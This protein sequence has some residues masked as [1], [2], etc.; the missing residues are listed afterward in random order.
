MAVQIGRSSLHMI[1]AHVHLEKGDYTIEWVQKFVQQAVERDIQEI[2]FLEHTHIFKECQ[3]LYNEMSTFN[4]YQRGWYQ[5]KLQQARPLKEYT[6]FIDQLKQTEFPIKMKFGLEVC[7]SPEREKEIAQLKE[8]YSFDFMV[9]SIHFIDGW[10]FSHLKQRWDKTEY[11][12]DRLYKRYY[13]LMLALAE[14]KLFS[15]LAHP[16]SLQCFGAY[17]ERDYEAVYMEIAQA[18]HRNQ[19]Y[20]EESSGLAINY[21]DKELG[22][23][24]RMLECM[25]QCNVPVLTVSDAHVPQNVGKHIKEME[26]YLNSIR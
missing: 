2:Y 19:M 10:A 15:G 7:Y 22:M 18:L 25:L 4:E 5:K 20:V 17:P 23:N 14:S 16:Q 12:M 21:S 26:N 11:D 8:L 9:G 24:H 3:S 13:E 6:D 1:D